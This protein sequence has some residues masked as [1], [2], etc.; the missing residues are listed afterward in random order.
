MKKIAQYKVIS[1]Q[2]IEAFEKQVNLF[3]NQGWYLQSGASCMFLEY[4]VDD[5]TN[6]SAIM[7]TQALVKYE[8]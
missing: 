8:E 7:Y 2:G 5:S 1:E 6:A 3:I 4:A